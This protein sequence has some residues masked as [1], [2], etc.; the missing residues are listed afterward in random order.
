[1]GFMKCLQFYGDRDPTSKNVTIARS[2][3]SP[4]P[5]PD[6]KAPLQQMIPEYALGDQAIAI[7][8]ANT[9]D[10]TDFTL[11]LRVRWMS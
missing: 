11:G 5:Q 6:R 3:V 4:R 1:M 10:A 9:P 2:G 8:S 7:W